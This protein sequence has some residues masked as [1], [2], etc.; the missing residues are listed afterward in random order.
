M[1]YHLFIFIILFRCSLVFYI[2]VHHIL[3]RPLCC[4]NCSTAVTR[5]CACWSIMSQQTKFSCFTTN[6]FMLLSVTLYTIS[7][8]SHSVEITTIHTVAAFQLQ[9]QIWDNLSDTLL[10]SCH[11]SDFVPLHFSPAKVSGIFRVFKL[12]MYAKEGERCSFLLSL[13]FGGWGV[14]NDLGI[15]LILSW[16]WHQVEHV[17]SL[18]EIRS[19]KRWNVPFCT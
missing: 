16:C 17:V 6:Y 12:D 2:C 13:F 15:T 10:S 11:L 7:K 5:A 18:V 4:R 3:N 1:S 9:V 8:N 19:E 14:Q